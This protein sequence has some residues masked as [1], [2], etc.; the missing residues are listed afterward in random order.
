[1]NIHFAAS[2]RE[3]CRSI[4]KYKKAIFWKRFLELLFSW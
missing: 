4:R 3:V 1:M 2:D